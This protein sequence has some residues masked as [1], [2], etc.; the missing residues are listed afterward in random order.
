MAKGQMKSNKEVR[1]QKADK[2][3]VA[4]PMGLLAGI[5][6]AAAKAKKKPAGGKN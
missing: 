5:A 4:Q 3:T 1:K 6:D 2:K